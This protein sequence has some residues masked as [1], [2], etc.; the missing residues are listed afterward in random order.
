MPHTRHIRVTSAALTLKRRRA[1]VT[2]RVVIALNSGEYAGA[3]ADI[4]PR[5]E[6]CMS[7]PRVMCTAAVFVALAN[8][9]QCVAQNSPDHKPKHHHYQFIDLGTFGGPTSVNFAIYPALNDEGTVI[10]G[11]DTSTPD[12][13]YPNFNPLMTP[14]ADPYTFKAFQSVNGQLVALDSLPGGYSASPSSI[15][16]NGLIA[17]QAINGALDPITGWPEEN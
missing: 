12:P 4:K 10:G 13:F 17:G 3:N 2:A 11:A 8:P 15:S 14:S 9:L 1:R 5:G 16:K 6:V 7:F